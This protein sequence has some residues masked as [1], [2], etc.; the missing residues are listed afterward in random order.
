VRVKRTFIAID[1]PYS[2]KMREC[3]NKLEHRLASQDIKW[4]PE[5]QM[6]LTL[7]FLGNIDENVIRKCI[8]VLK[9][10]ATNYHPFS[11]NIRDL[12]VFKNIF[13]PRIIWFGVEKNETLIRLK[14]DIEK[15]FV[16]LG[17]EPD[18]KNFN[19][20][21]T[22]GRIK[23]LK[24]KEALKELL[25]EYKDQVFHTVDVENIVFYESILK[26]E[27]PIYLPIEKIQLT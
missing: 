6:H 20:H 7:K 27:G 22:I 3:Q 11:F 25:E 21:L 8:I 19:P 17:F 13:Y 4:T 1:I 16:E 24:S 26:P 12:G 2:H 5:N 14:K 10:I 23:R 18:D 15:R 9:D